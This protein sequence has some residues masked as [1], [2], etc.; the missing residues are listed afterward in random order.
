MTPLSDAEARSI[1]GLF[2]S[3]VVG[4]PKTGNT[5]GEI[6]PCHH[7]SAG[8]ESSGNAGIDFDPLSPIG[9]LQIDSAVACRRYLRRKEPGKRI[10]IAEPDMREFFF[11]QILLRRRGKVI[12]AYV[13]D[14]KRRRRRQ[15][16]CC[17]YDRR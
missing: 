3:P 7:S 13:E 6:R 2:T 5:K 12:V 10:R 1:N 4:A 9:L 11:R 15:C 14:I 17:C 8:G 16:C